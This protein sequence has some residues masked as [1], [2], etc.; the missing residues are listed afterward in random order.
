MRVCVCVYL[1]VDGRLMR[2]VLASWRV[3]V[4][5]VHGG[6]LGWMSGYSRK[7]TCKGYRRYFV[8]QS[9]PNVVWFGR[10]RVLPIGCTDSAGCVLILSLILD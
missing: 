5:S 9:L 7:G 2:V 6:V 4:G 8:G 1:P 3:S 10:W